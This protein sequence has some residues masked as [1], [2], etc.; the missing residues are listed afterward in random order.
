MGQQVCTRGVGGAKAQPVNMIKIEVNSMAKKLPTPTVG[1]FP[2]QSTFQR[3][4]LGRRDVSR[5]AVV[6]EV[7]MAILQQE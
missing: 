5:A 3:E 4:I 1:E 2:H 7:E 6:S